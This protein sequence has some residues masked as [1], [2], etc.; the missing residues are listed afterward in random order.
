MLLQ[1]LAVTLRKISA[2][3]MRWRQKGRRD[4]DIPTLEEAQDEK[5]GG[6]AGLQ[7]SRGVQFPLL[8]L[9]ERKHDLPTDLSQSGKLKIVS[10][11]AD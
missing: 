1:I 10:N 8:S 6:P 7:D 4:G 3:S 5:R 9:L 2:Q 11:P